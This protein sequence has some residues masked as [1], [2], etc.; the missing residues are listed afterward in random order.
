MNCR[1]DQVVSTTRTALEKISIGKYDQGLYLDEKR[2]HS[3]I[4]GGLLT[5]FIVVTIVTYMSVIFST[6][7]NRDDYTLNE[8]STLFVNSGITNLTIGDI[9]DELPLSFELDLSSFAGYS[10]C[11]DVKL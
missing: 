11:E 5:V 2:H 8:S 3:S 7:F 6:V 1:K 4:C 10:K 9:R